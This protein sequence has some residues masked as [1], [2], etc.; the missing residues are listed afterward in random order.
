MFLDRLAFLASGSIGNS[1]LKDTRSPQKSA[2]GILGEV[3][4]S[5]SK[6]I[7]DVETR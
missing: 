3:P 4:R 6:I 1:F 2:T 5:F 7:S